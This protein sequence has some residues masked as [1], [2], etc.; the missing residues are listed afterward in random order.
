VLFNLLSWQL[1]LSGAPGFLSNIFVSPTQFLPPTL[2]N[3]FRTNPYCSWMVTLQSLNVDVTN[4]EINFYLW[5][6]ILTR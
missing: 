2:K 1:L 5:Q 6:V 3:D 4:L